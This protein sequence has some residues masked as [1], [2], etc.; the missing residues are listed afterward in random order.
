MSARSSRRCSFCKTIGAVFNTYWNKC[1]A[2]RS[3]V[4]A[5]GK[6]FPDK[7]GTLL[8]ELRFLRGWIDEDYAGT[9]KCR[10][11]SRPPG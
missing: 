5:S 8:D 11:C 6:P 2:P 3:G 4:D 1:A 10:P 9:G 7:Q